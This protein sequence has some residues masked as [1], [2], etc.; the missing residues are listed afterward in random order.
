MPGW[1]RLNDSE[2]DSFLNGFRAGFD[3]SREGFNRE[4]VEED[5]APWPDHLL[6]DPRPQ[7]AAE[8][9]LGLL[10][11]RAL[12]ITQCRHEADRSRRCIHCKAPMGV[13]VEAERR[14]A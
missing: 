2:R 8:E 4:R 10:A 7:R 9:L 6:A 14:R 3:V 5:R 13:P 1:Y 11:A 12:A